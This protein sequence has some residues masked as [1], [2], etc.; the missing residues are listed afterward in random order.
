MVCGEVEH[1]SCKDDDGSE[2]HTGLQ[3]ATHD[4]LHAAIVEAAGAFSTGKSGGLGHSLPVHP[5]K[6]ISAPSTRI[7]TAKMLRDQPAA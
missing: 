6:I 5:L 1:G 2:Q 4:G 7:T 3:E